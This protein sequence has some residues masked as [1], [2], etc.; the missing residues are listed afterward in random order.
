MIYQY[1]RI[2]HMLRYVLIAAVVFTG[3]RT[4]SS[5]SEGKSIAF[6]SDRTLIEKMTIDVSGEQPVSLIIDVTTDRPQAD[7]KFHAE[8]LQ[9]TLEQPDSEE[10]CTRHLT[11][12]VTRGEQGTLPLVVTDK[13]EESG[14]YMYGKAMDTKIVSFS[15]LLLTFEKSKKKGKA[16]QCRLTVS[17]GG[18]WSA[19]GDVGYD[20][21]SDNPKRDAAVREYSAGFD[22]RLSH[23]MWHTSRGAWPTMNERLAILK[24]ENADPAQ[25]SVAKQE[26]QATLEKAKEQ[27]E[28]S[29][30]V[31]PRPFVKDDVEAT[32][33]SG[34]GEDFLYMH[35]MMIKRLTAYLRDRNLP[36]IPAWQTLPHPDDKQFTLGPKGHEPLP[37]HKS[38]EYYYTI[39]RIWEKAYKMPVID[40][41]ALEELAQDLL[42]GRKKT[43][44][45]EKTKDLEA[46][47]IEVGKLLEPKKDYHYRGLKSVTLGEY[48]HLLEMTLHNDLH[49]RYA[50]LGTASRPGNADPLDRS[51]WNKDWSYAFDNPNYDSLNDTFSSHVHPWFYRIHGWV[52]DRIGDWLKANGYQSIG[53]KD[54]CAK[55]GEACY[56]W[57]SD[58]RYAFAEEQFP[59]EGPGAAEEKLTSDRKQMSLHAHKAPAFTPDVVAA[60]R[61]YRAPYASMNQILLNPDLKR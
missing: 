17:A 56:V 42:E 29:G 57:L 7:A 40:S 60:T 10:G 21:V 41:A 38:D 59:W 22:H 24:A 48:G 26:E 52:D 49:T 1:S 43:N 12:V 11:A 28:A 13:D 58:S 6:V 20:V 37:D 51:A 9:I 16:N 30:W 25:T 31:P 53:T 14:S 8:S 27:Y 5:N 47:L 33:K 3:C 32:G 44:T 55:V 2:I 46:A 50:F 18:Y 39:E 34:A 4:V 54:E 35:R 23:F 19:S 36:M 45:A 15:E 61:G